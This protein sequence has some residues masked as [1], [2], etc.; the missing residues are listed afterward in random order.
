MIK[1]EKGLHVR[2]VYLTRPALTFTRRNRISMW[3]IKIVPS[4][5]LLSFV[6][7]ILF[8]MYLIIYSYRH[9][10]KSISPWGFGIV[11]IGILLKGQTFGYFDQ[12]V[13]FRI[14]IALVVSL[15][16]VLWNINNIRNLFFTRN[17]GVFF[18][19]LGLG[20]LFGL[21]LYLRS[22]Q[23]INYIQVDYQSGTLFALIAYVIQAS[24]AEELLYRG[25]ILGY[26]RKCEINPII[27]I[28]FQALI[29][30]LAHFSQDT[31][32][33]MYI[34]EVFMVGITTGYL[35]WRSNNLVPA[36][37]LHS[38]TNLVA[39]FWLLPVH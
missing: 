12:I 23:N 13:V 9:R 22:P 19:N 8:W 15:F 16:G 38:I 26:L 4:F 34:L 21:L 27:S 2:G 20:L 28:L 39:V 36:F 35:T 6:L 24:M 32:N 30:I 37:V 31:G 7:L 11:I 17:F 29:F 1:N 25:Y 5:G 10:E 14:D 3:N 33:W 18:R